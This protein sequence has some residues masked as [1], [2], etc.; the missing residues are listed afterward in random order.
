MPLGQKE[1]KACRT[2]NFG[3]LGESVTSAGIRKKEP[4]RKPDRWPS[5]RTLI[6]SVSSVSVW[7]TRRPTTT[8]ALFFAGD[9]SITVLNRYPYNN[10]HCW[11]LPAGTWDVWTSFCRT[12]NSSCREITQMVGL[13][14][15]VIQPQGFNVGLNLGGRPGRACPAICIGNRSPLDGDT[16]FMPMLANVNVIPQSLDALWEL[17]TH[18][19]L[20]LRRERSK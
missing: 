14:E 6:R 19:W 13:L 7:P 4:Q 15:K 18:A 3:R 12:S 17:L 5:C 9:R 20:D 2:N 10:G 1:Q 8:G 11:L 16:N